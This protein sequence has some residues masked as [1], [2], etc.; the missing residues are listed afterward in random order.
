[1]CVFLLVCVCVFVCLC[2]CVLV[3]CHANRLP[4]RFHAQDPDFSVDAAVLLCSDFPQEQQ[5]LLDLLEE[6]QS[7]LVLALRASF[8]RMKDKEIEESGLET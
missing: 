6:Q 5:K 2:V 7:H 1:M 8:N 4:D 3:S